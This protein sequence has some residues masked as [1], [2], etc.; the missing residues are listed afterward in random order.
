MTQ[1]V[2]QVAMEAGNSTQVI[3][4]HYRELVTP[5]EAASWL[6]IRPTAG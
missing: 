6:G 4:K 2:A 5:K 3:F 1:N